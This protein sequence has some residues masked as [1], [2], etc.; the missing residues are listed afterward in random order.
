M[1]ACFFTRNSLSFAF[2][3]P[4]LS[5][6]GRGERKFHPWGGV[7]FYPSPRNNPLT[8]LSCGVVISVFTKLPCVVSILATSSRKALD[9]ILNC[10]H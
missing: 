8:V 10:P 2:N 7:C 3:R 9:E 4:R 6:L 5:S 1:A